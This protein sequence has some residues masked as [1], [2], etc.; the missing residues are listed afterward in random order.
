MRIFAGQQAYFATLLHE[1][2]FIWQTRDPFVGTRE[3]ELLTPLLDV[4]DKI[5][6]GKG[7]PLTVLES[8]CGEGV[9][10][11]LLKK[12]IESQV[13]DAFV[14]IDPIESAIL[15]AQSHGVDARIGDGLSLPFEDN[16]YDVVFCRDVLHH[17]ADDV[18]RKRFVDEMKRVARP[19]GVVVI[20][21]PNPYNP[22]LFCFALFV[23]A[24]RG[25]LA[26]DEK[27]VRRLFPLVK[28]T[29][30]LPSIA[31][32]LGYHYRSPL[33]G[34]PFWAKPLKWILQ[35]WES[36]CRHMPT[37]FWAYRC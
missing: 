9:N 31:W 21:E 10:I 19:G 23:S 27:R 24:E 26:M 35:L 36:L 33:L 17:L 6:L 15:T 3:K 13:S 20:I 16:T 32:R 12:F 25:V 1:R 2:K 28:V 37:K 29:R 4:L 18:A 11:A 8:G 14:G 30:L 22:T 7:G 5:R 34:W